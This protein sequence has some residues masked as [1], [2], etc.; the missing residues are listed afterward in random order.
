[1]SLSFGGVRFG[2]GPQNENRASS[3][4]DEFFRDRAECNF[5]PAG[6]SMRGDDDHVDVVMPCNPY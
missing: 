3:L 5:A 4:F 2:G 1:M 6:H